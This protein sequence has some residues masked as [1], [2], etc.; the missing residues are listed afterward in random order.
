MTGNSVNGHSVLIVDDE[1]GIRHGLKNMFQKEGFCVFESG[2]FEHSIKTVH[3]HWVDVAVLDIR[4]KGARNGIDLLKE[5]KRIEPGLIIIVITGYG[6]IDTAV[7]SMKEGASDYILKPIDNRS[8]LDTVRKNIQLRNLKNQNYYLKKELLG[9]FNYRFLTRNENL[10][11]LIHKADRIKNSPVTVLISG[12]SGAGKEVLAR[13]IH[14]TSNRKDASFVTINC[15]A[16]S[17]NLLLSELFGHE[18]GAFTGAVERKTGK[19]EIAHR[20]SLFLDEIGDMPMDIQAKIL[21]VIEEQSFERV[22]GTKKIQVDIRI[23]AAT[24]KD[25][26]KNIS[27]G[28]FRE[29]LFYRINVVSFHLTPLRNR[30]EDIPVLTKH[31]M[32]KY[33][34]MYNKKVAGIDPSALES[35]CRYSWPGNVRELDNVINQVVLLNEGE[36]I[37]N[38]ELKK[39]LLGSEEEEKPSV[40]FSSITSLKHAV[41]TLRQDYEKK[42]ILHFLNR[43]NYNKSRTARALSITRKTLSEKIHRYGINPG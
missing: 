28:M 4:L 32:E 15:A 33:S 23:I 16:L 25:L 9:R 19:I 12:E 6:S 40:D 14:F 37:T 29:D 27:E 7:T 10:R 26:E 1:E 36:V 11:S 3:E 2:S 41:E 18:K 13:Y 21:R 43:Y 8:L 17:E 34:T 31:F 5:L 39:S 42:I 30:K 38:Q 35:L 22:G 20:G 24:N